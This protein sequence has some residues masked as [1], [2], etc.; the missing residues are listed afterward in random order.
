MLYSCILDLSHS[1]YF[2]YQSWQ[3][4]EKGAKGSKFEYQWE[5]QFNCDISTLLKCLFQ[6]NKVAM[7]ALALTLNGDVKPFHKLDIKNFRLPSYESPSWEDF[8]M[9]SFIFLS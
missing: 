2:S 1:F 5:Q 7:Y 3:E 8:K 6:A 4:K 9:G